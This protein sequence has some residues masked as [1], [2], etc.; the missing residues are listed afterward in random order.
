MSLTYT[1]HNHSTLSETNWVSSDNVVVEFMSWQKWLKDKKIYIKI[2]TELTPFF[3]F[4]LHL[5]EIENLS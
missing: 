4:F 5:L 3:D 2:L 1:A